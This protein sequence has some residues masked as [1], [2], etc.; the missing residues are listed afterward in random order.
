MAPPRDSSVLLRF[1]MR[2]P[3]RVK[4]ELKAG[5][6]HSRAVREYTDKS[7]IR[8]VMVKTGRHEC[9]RRY[10]DRLDKD[11]SGTVELHEMK[12]WLP[13]IGLGEASAGD[14]IQAHF[15][16]MDKDGTGEVDFKEFCKATLDAAD[17][18]LGHL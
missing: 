16:F 4:E 3:G 7:T 1:D 6:L 5:R 8:P 17:Q 14:A 10:F 2:L 12:R 13:K 9:L 18:R 15:A 11:G